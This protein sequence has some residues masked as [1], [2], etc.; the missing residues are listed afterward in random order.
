MEKQRQLFENRYA[1]EIAEGDISWDEMSPEE[2]A[3]ICEVC[4]RILD[5]EMPIFDG[6][7][8]LC[9]GDACEGQV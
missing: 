9:G 1:E 5:P 4:G 6:D 3:S 2:K 7:S 8:V